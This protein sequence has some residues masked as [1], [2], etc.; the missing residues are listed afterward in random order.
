MFTILQYQNEFQTSQWPNPDDQNFLA[1]SN[2]CTSSGW[3]T[4]ESDGFLIVF[5]M[6]SWNSSGFRTSLA[7][8]CWVWGM[9]HFRCKGEVEMIFTCCKLK[10][11]WTGLSIFRSPFMVVYAHV[12]EYAYT[13]YMNYIFRAVI[14]WHTENLF[15]KLSMLQ[16]LT[17]SDDRVSV[18]TDSLI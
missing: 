11:D 8:S 12:C 4:A 7:V 6:I 5:S 18:F 14:W 1:G 16:L 3:F 17:P 13:S 10:P 9:G 2:D 15:I